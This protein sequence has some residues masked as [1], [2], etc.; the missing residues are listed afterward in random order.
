[1]NTFHTLT[2]VIPIFN[3][4]DIL[5]SNLHRIRSF[6][7]EKRYDYTLVLA[8]DG[9]TDGSDEIL[10]KE[11][12]K[13]PEKVVVVRQEKNVGKG[14]ILKQ[15]F[16]HGESKYYAFLDADLEIDVSY[17]EHL[18]VRLEEGFDIA[19][20]SRAVPGGEAKRGWMRNLVQ[21]IYRFVLSFLFKLSIRDTQ[22]GLKAFRR[23][24]LFPLMKKTV[25]NDWLWD[26]EILLLANRSG[27]RI[28]EVP[29]V[30]I[31]RRESHL[32]FFK[33]VWKC[34]L[35]LLELRRR[36]KD[37]SRRKIMRVVTRMNIGG[38]ALHALF[39]TEGMNHGQFESLLVS[40]STEPREGNLLELKGHPRI[41]VHAVPELRRKIH[42]V[43]DWISFWKLLRLFR[44][45]RPDIVHTHMAKA[46]ALGRLAALLVGVPVRVHTY[47]GHVFHD[48]FNGPKTR[49][50][51]AVE[52]WLA[53]R[54]DCLIAVSEEVRQ[55]LSQKYRIGSPEKI[56]VIPLGLD[57]DSFL[58]AEKHRGFLRR[59]LGLSEGIRLIGIVG[60]LVPVKDHAFFLSIAAE[61]LKRHQDVHF[62]IVGD[63]EL[64]ETLETE[65]QRRSLKRHVTF[66]G[67]RKDLE[68][69]Y[70]DLDVV[71]QT[72][73]NEGTPVS[74]I[75]A[76]AAA[77]PVVSTR[78]GGVP[79]VVQE[80]VTGYLVSP[81]DGST[82]CDRI[83]FLL[84][85]AEIRIRFG[86][87]GREWVRD[88]YSKERL[89][90]DMKILYEELLEN[91]GKRR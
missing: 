11:S 77:R 64:R 23:E 24:A 48:Y 69:I 54:S 3:E 60:R 91:R 50:F 35:G 19:I 70:P 41:S 85:H 34:G 16:L 71:V 80:G 62:V 76:M 82:F 44:R 37:G 17:L 63:G 74:L 55:E 43:T 20:G 27:L 67:W 5:E 7:E 84:D 2:L 61:L 78:V 58:D 66:L 13:H 26:L 88:R 9:S 57:L 56:R 29:V 38:P 42:P 18:L 46:G 68:R 73:K 75:E 79:D 72:S 4:R 15:G 28:A 86:E 14:G 89:I 59:E 52:R 83:G 6:L 47:H 39:L 87:R 25:R 30:S 36:Q 53:R 21:A 49:F 8:D 1:M 90:S 65:C 22:A 45:E 33:I 81:G 51:L 10:Q 12:L 31:A 40:G 32:K